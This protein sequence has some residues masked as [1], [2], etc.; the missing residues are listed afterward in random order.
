MSAEV[1]ELFSLYLQDSRPHESNGSLVERPP[2]IESPPSVPSISSSKEDNARSVT[3]NSEQKPSLGDAKKQRRREQNRRAAV[4]SRKRKKFYLRELETKVDALKTRNEELVARLR[5]LE[6]ENSKLKL[7]RQPKIARLKESAA[8]VRSE[9]SSQTDCQTEPGERMKH[10]PTVVKC[11]SAALTSQQRMTIERVFQFSIYI[12]LAIYMAI[13]QLGLYLSPKA[14]VPPRVSGLKQ[15]K[16][17][18][19]SWPKTPGRSTPSQALKSTTSLSKT[20]VVRKK[21][22][23][24]TP[25]PPLRFPALRFLLYAGFVT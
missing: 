12:L 23:P 19:Q 1:H 21:F 13:G 2:V 16:S 3:N 11:E 8:V 10:I 4:K 7:Y 6:E 15:V 22:F 18:R 9:E 14:S 17:F 20:D 25:F 24:N 5:A